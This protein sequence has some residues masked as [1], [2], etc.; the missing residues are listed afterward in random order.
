MPW[1]PLRYCIHAGCGERGDGPR[2]SGPWASERSPL[3]PHRLARLLHP[4]EITSKQI[5]I[6][7]TSL[8]GYQRETFVDAW[9]RYLPT[10]PS[11]VE[12]K[13]RNSEHERRFRCFGSRPL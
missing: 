1:A 4:F 8:K 13:H 7:C 3:T 2:C 11:P 6:G 10:P 5:R 12:P 9:E